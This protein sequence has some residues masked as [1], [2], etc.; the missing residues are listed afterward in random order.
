MNLGFNENFVSDPNPVVIGTFQGLS[1]DVS[2][3]IGGGNY[4]TQYEAATAEDVKVF[5]GAEKALEIGDKLDLEAALK[6][7]HASSRLVSIWKLVSGPSPQ[8]GW[9]AIGPGCGA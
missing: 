8:L 4:I 6:V 7:L 2:V 5:R 3:G 1:G 9:L